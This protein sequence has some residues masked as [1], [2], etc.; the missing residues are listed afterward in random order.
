AGAT[1]LAVVI[2]IGDLSPDGTDREGSPGR[3][4]VGA[5]SRIRIEPARADDVTPRGDRAAVDQPDP[6]HAGDQLLHDAGVRRCVRT[7]VPAVHETAWSQ[8]Q[9]VP[10]VAEPWTGDRLHLF[11]GHGELAVPSVLR[12]SGEERRV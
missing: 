11:H 5:R 7:G 12:A 3:R 1:G 9:L 4:V 2:L 8:D 10:V 6:P